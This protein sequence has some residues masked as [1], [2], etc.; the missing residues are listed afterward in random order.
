M[1]KTSKG[2]AETELKASRPSGSLLTA[3]PRLPLVI[4]GQRTLQARLLRTS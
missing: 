2:S 1:A 3:D 4:F